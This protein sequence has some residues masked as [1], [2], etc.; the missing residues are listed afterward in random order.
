MLMV[1]FLVYFQYIAWLL[2]FFFFFFVINTLLFTDKKKDITKKKMFVVVPWKIQKR[3][4]NIINITS[5]LMPLLLTLPLNIMLG[6]FDFWALMRTNTNN[7][8]REHQWFEQR[9]MH[10]LILLFPLFCCRN[11]LVN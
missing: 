10:F 1:P 9:Q 2:V 3:K 11:L 4:R 7:P 8:S 6:S 5:R